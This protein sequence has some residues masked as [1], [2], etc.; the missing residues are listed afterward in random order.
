MSET[1]KDRSKRKFR[2]N[3]LCPKCNKGKI[4][5]CDCKGCGKRN[6]ESFLC[7]ICHWTNF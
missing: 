6:K 5:F 3:Q 4:T 2:K 7:K 1:Y